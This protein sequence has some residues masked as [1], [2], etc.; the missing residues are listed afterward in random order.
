[1]H[2]VDEKDAPDGYKA[3]LMGT[4]GCYDCA[5]IARGATSICQTVNCMPSQRKDGY[6]V[7]FQKLSK[8]ASRKA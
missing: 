4:C 5:F 8:A 2:Q 6:A 1:M 3:I 7:V